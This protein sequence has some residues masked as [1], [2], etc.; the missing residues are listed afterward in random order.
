VPE[1]S[2]P[3]SVT[4]IAAL[5]LEAAG[6]SVSA[7]ALEAGLGKTNVGAKPLQPAPGPAGLG[8]PGG[9]G[10]DKRVEQSRVDVWAAEDR[11][12]GFAVLLIPNFYA[13]RKDFAR[14][15][16]RASN[17]WLRLC[18]AVHQRLTVRSGRSRSTCRHVRARVFVTHQ[19]EVIFHNIIRLRRPF[20]A[21]GQTTLNTMFSRYRSLGALGLADSVKCWR[22]AGTTRQSETLYEK[23]SLARSD[24]RATSSVTIGSCSPNPLF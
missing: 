14:I 2:A 11:G 12:G 5:E 10:N 16:L 19:T 24:G 8:W 15:A 3:A 6:S 1:I 17:V 18:R 9:G 22:T 21:V 13:R 7:G 4:A 23:P 20:P